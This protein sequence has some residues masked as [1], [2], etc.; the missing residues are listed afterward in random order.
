MNTITIVT[1]LPRSGTSLM[2]QILNQSS[3]P[4][5]IDGVRE[6]D[7][8]NPKGYFE[9][10]AVK[11]IVKDNSFLNDAHGKAVKIVCPLPMYLDLNFKYRVLVMRR[12]MEEIL[13]SQEKMLNKD[14]SG[15][16]ISFS[17]I[18]TNHLDRMYAFFKKNNIDYI[19]V[20]Y[21]ELIANSEEVIDGIVKFCKLEN[22][23]KELKNVISPDL[24]RNKN[25]AK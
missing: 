25:E 3:L 13:S 19:D 1:G 24:Y 20:W 12:N 23:L 7:I 2:M 9:L 15:I 16:K 18:Y 6:K 14:Q 4:L 21:P 5:F 8:N 10:E 11:K 22:N 17:K